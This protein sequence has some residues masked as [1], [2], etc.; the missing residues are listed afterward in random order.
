M[1]TAL[2]NLLSILP[3]NGYLRAGMVFLFYFVIAELVALVIERVLMKFAKKTKTKV[4]DLIIQKTKKP[5]VLIII[6]IGFRLAGGQI[7]ILGSA[8]SIFANIL[9]SIT[10]IIGMWIVI[11]IIEIF[12]WPEI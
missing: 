6:L 12:N 11:S 5:I 10:V 1:N 7:P 4:D 9:S 3:D 2:L 8:L